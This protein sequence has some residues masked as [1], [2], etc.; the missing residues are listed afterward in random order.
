MTTEQDA[1][2][3]AKQAVL[4]EV[5]PDDGNGPDADRLPALVDALIA[6]AEQRGRD[7]IRDLWKL[8][9]DEWEDVAA[10]EMRKVI[11]R[12]EQAEAQL[13]RAN[14]T[15]GDA[16]VLAQSKFREVEAQRD[17]L[18]E[19]ARHQIDCEREMVDPPR[20]GWECSCGFAALAAMDAGASS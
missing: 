6:D 7:E 13:A 16:V 11:A 1:V 4:A 18:R 3:A 2:K 14:V 15:L 19:Y 17:R 8:D 5:W 20:S 10:C 9:R 12:A